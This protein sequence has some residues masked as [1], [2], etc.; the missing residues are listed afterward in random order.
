MYILYD[1]VQMN[2]QPKKDRGAPQHYARFGMILCLIA[3]YTLMYFVKYFIFKYNSVASEV[4]VKLCEW[5]LKFRFNWLGLLI[6]LHFHGGNNK[7]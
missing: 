1:K 5:V 3:A 4:S 2:A 6:N 7:K